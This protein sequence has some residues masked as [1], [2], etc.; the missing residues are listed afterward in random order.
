MA[1][2]K[3]VMTMRDIIDIEQTRFDIIGDDANKRTF[4]RKDEL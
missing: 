3:E 2:D 4:L 1:S